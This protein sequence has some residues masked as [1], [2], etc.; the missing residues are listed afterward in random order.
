MKKIIFVL[1]YNEGEQWVE[2][3]PVESYKNI[4]DDPDYQVIFLDNGNQPL[5]REWA[6]KTNSIYFASEN[7]I[8]TTGGYN[9]FIRVGEVLNADRIAVM[10]ADVEIHDPVCLKYLFESPAKE[11]WQH[12]QF[13][14]WP[15][16]F[17]KT[18]RDDNL[19]PDV[20]QFFSL[21]PRF[22]LDNDYLCD[23]NYTVT[24]FESVDLFLRMTNDH[25]YFPAKPVNLMSFFPDKDVNK[26][27]GEK[28]K[29]PL[30]TIH[31]TTNRLGLHDRWF[32]YNFPYFKRK[33]SKNIDIKP[34]HAAHLFGR[35]ATLWLTQ[36]WIINEDRLEFTK[37]FMHKK[38]LI[39]K[40]N[41]DVG[42]MPYPVE[43]EVNRFYVE[44][45]KPILSQYK[46]SNE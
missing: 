14:Y 27:Y 37:I 26:L 34:E 23:E 44:I 21:N 35:G 41:I 17:R 15:N 33:W 43:Y 46:Y 13:I 38:A 31:S 10:Q 45:I 12:D 8:G 5:I 32:L 29:E 28:Q 42:Q 36:P 16:N 39:T 11:A 40:R 18:W 4:F 1:T 20:G 19:D 22:F 3:Y 24:H 30:Y 9:W 25:N 7:N 2:T 6:E